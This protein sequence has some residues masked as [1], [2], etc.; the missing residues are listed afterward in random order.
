MTVL[1]TNSRH[2][3][4]V[5][6]DKADILLHAVVAGTPDLHVAD[7]DLC[8]AFQ[9]THPDA[10]IRFWD[11]TRKRLSTFQGLC[12]QH[13]WPWKSRHI[14]ANDLEKRLLATRAG[15]FVMMCSTNGFERQRALEAIRQQPFVL[16]GLCL[17][18][19][20]IRLNDWADQVAY[21]A[22]I[23][24]E[25]CT[26]GTEI[27]L[28]TLTACFPMYL[29]SADWGRL[30]TEDRA[31]LDRLFDHDRAR[32]SF[33]AMLI[34]STN[35]LNAKTLNWM[36]RRPDWDRDLPHI[37]SNAR[38]W[39]LRLNAL[40]ALLSGK[41]T[42]KEQGGGERVIDVAHDPGQLVR[43]AMT[44][45]SPSIRLLGLRA[46][47]EQ[48]SSDLEAARA[49][50]EH[51]VLDPS[52]KVAICAAFWLRRANG[53]PA[54]VIRARI[55]SGPPPT[56]SSLLLLGGVGNAADSPILLQ[57]STRY[58]GR[59]K[60]AL[61]AAAAKLTPDAVIP[62]L[63]S[64][65]TSIDADDTEA[66]QAVKALTSLGQSLDVEQLMAWTK[67][68]ARF[69]ARNF[70]GMTH[71]LTPWRTVEVLLALADNGMSDAALES[72]LMQA[73]QRTQRGG[74]TLNLDE[75]NRL[76]TSLERLP[77]QNSSAIN[78]LSWSLKTR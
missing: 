28:N 64:V 31:L 32:Q 38:H 78:L 39:N 6:A 44:D 26:T 69:L 49:T 47:A 76:L 61:L 54:A 20:L 34:E 75:R 43:Q 2:S 27:D 18:L 33:L 72:D 59:H 22:R 67:Q 16:S 52:I 65:A 24:L 68:P 48:R 19:L 63:N 57:A 9:V 12:G 5:L 8:S 13:V 10:S 15:P 40:R 58:A 30:R 53:D 17:A 29:A 55:S 11:I 41:Y 51:F 42:W 56:I 14:E 77:R 50:F 4:N 21:T 45:H 73:A 7:A 25:S 74:M 62:M 3:S 71:R 37:A 36:L 70:L 60:W 35:S 66:R 1:T 23:T 46:F